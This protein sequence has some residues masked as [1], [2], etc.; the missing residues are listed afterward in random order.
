MVGLFVYLF[1]IITNI[2][3]WI[4]AKPPFWIIVI[5]GTTTSLYGFVNLASSGS[6]FDANAT[7]SGENHDVEDEL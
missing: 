7:S 5:D 6:A 2:F 4:G 3:F 1:A